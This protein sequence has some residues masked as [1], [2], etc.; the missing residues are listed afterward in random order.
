MQDI[1]DEHEIT[2]ARVHQILTRRGV[3]SG[4]GRRVRRELQQHRENEALTLFWEE[5]GTTVAALAE[6]GASKSEVLAKFRMLFPATDESLV[7]AALDG[8]EVVFSKQ[9]DSHHFPESAVRFGLLW[10]A[11]ANAG[12]T[13]DP[14][15]ALT[16]LD[17]DE[18][19][20]AAG[21]LRERE[22]SP[23]EIASIF[24]IVASTMER[25]RS[26]PITITKNRY[27]ELREPFVARP[28]GDAAHPWPADG[29]TVSK[30]LG[31]GYWDDAIVSVGLSRSGR[32]RPR[33]L[34]TFTEAEY[35]DAV[36]A[37]RANQIALGYGVSAGSYDDWREREM[38]G[39][40][41]RPS[42]A[43]VRLRFGTWHAAIRAAVTA[44]A[45]NAAP[46]QREALPGARLLHA[47][48]VDAEQGIAAFVNAQNVTE[49]DSAVRDF[50][51]TYAQSF[52]V[53]RRLW[54]RAMVATDPSAG[55][56][57][58][59]QPKR[60]F[61]GYAA[62]TTNPNRPLDAIDDTYLDRL[63][64]TADL[65]KVDGWFSADVEAALEPLTN[66]SAR[67][68]VLRS[69]RN[70]VTHLSDNS[71]QR[72]LT[73]LAAATGKEPIFNYNRQLSLTMFVRWLAANDGERLRN[74]A[75]VLPE[76][77]TIMLTAEG[78]LRSEQEDQTVAE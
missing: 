10:A 4:V 27:M 65:G 47:G 35:L 30:R 58:A 38:Q 36:V 54:F 15:A 8:S 50:V 66:L 63:L 18:M 29:Q 22:F 20:D 17:V 1:A 45:V 68:E 37:F 53:D 44:P 13:G 41:S 19:L 73:A 49:K 74:L 56:R 28:R 75:D 31:G 42:L 12:I 67:Y 24:A 61:S 40:R 59:A 7:A 23:D 72:L 57:R 25:V 64:S 48:R 34:L 26:E 52:E 46:R 33:G 21:A 2:R 55:P 76:A 5:H 71:A 69:A 16:V 39:G 32:G 3:E 78:V 77:W 43:G 14:G 9:D 60:G 11:G 70:Y 62:L 6:D 51:K